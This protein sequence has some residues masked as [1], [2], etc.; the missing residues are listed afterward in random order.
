MIDNEGRDPL[1]VSSETGDSLANENTEND[2]QSSAYVVEQ[3]APNQ[4][5]Q[6]NYGEIPQ[7]DSQQ[8]T[9]YPEYL[10]PNINSMSYDP[11]AERKGKKHKKFLTALISICCVMAIAV[12]AII[13]Y[14][15]ISSG[16]MKNTLGTSSKQAINSSSQTEPE[17]ANNA[18]TNRE[19][20]TIYQLS[21]PEDALT[22][23]E[24]VEKV[25]DSVV[26]ISCLFS[27]GT[28][29]GTGII[30]SEDGYI[31][32]NAHV[33]NG[34]SDITVVFT[35]DQE[36]GIK[37]ELI[38]IDTQTDLAVIKIEKTG[39]TPA[40]FGKSSELQVG[41]AA[42]VIGNPLGFQLAGSVTSGI[43]SALDREL[44]IEDKTLTL[45]QTD[46]SINSGNSGGALINAY[47][48]VVGVTSAKI[49]SAYGEGLGFA[50]PIDGALPIIKDLIENGYVTGRPKLGISGSDIS[51]FYSEYYGI[52]QGFQV[53]SVEE[54]SAAQEAGIKVG[55][56]VVGIEGKLITGM[57]EFNEIKNTFSAGDT[58]SVSLYR[59]G[60]RTDVDVTLGEASGDTAAETTT[61][62]TTYRVFGGWGY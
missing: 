56:I 54:G 47:G 49:N 45:I 14:S 23:P 50:I 3:N 57:S 62:A 20:P 28:G 22:I 40:E 34:A 51:S 11:N 7:Q 59:N 5:A 21:A 58:I 41:E 53:E 46:A 8:Y 19:L 39:L 30:M 55:D 10:Q 16:T 37:A 60:K 31:I 12:T 13:G 38:G 43:I 44:T 32:T 1:N 6:P 9:P 18:K 29:T 36:N 33:V 35:E 27:N 52:P 61:E 24:V 17:K 2:R 42:I 26:G 25:S 15:L 48:Q 4:N